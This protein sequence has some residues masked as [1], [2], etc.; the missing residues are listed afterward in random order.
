MSEDTPMDCLKPLNARARRNESRKPK[1]VEYDNR[2][3]AQTATIRK[4]R[5]RAEA[6]FNEIEESDRFI[7]TP[8]DEDA[9]PT[10]RVSVKS[11]KKG[12]RKCSNCRQLGH[13]KTTCKNDKVEAMEVRDKDASM[14]SLVFTSNSK[15]I[16]TYSNRSHIA[17]DDTPKPKKAKAMT[18]A[19]ARCV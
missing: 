12:T 1:Q 16:K 5:T 15:K 8:D 14:K 10:V 7:G 3:P 17:Q 4:K 6:L 18:K 11:E 13:T 2:T 19:E 9:D